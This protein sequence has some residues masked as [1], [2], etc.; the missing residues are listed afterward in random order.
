M[1][2]GIPLFEIS[3]IEIGGLNRGVATG[4]ATFTFDDSVGEV[5]VAH[6]ITVKVRLRAD[7]ATTI[8]DIREAIFQKAVS[9]LAQTTALVSGKTER[10]LAIEV[11]EK[12]ASDDV[13]LNSWKTFTPEL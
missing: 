4:E 8:H 9:V 6:L 1:P 5:E 3:R 12:L 10:Q 2:L 11:E 7:E 13:E